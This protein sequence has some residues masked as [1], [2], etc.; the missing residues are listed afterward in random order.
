[1]EQKSYWLSEKYI[2][3]LIGAAA[4]EAIDDF[5][6]EDEWSDYMTFNDHL[7]DF[8]TFRREGAN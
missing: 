2:R 3:I 5:G 1:M 6:V 4:C 8:K 7:Q